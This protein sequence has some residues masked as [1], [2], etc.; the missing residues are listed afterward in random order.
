MLALDVVSLSA[1]LGIWGGGGGTKRHT[2]D[3]SKI[4]FLINSLQS[5]ADNHPVLPA[6]SD[7]SNLLKNFA[8]E[9]VHTHLSVTNYIPTHSLSKSS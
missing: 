7:V 8:S 9:T 2:K 1:F 6:S 3:L 4:Q 5:M